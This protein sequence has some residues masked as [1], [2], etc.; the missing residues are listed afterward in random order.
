MMATE[1]EAFRYLTRGAYLGGFL[2]SPGTIP[3][4]TG[5]LLVV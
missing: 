5:R 3:E 4:A 1:G 2:Q